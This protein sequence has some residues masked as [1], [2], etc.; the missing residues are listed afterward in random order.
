MFGPVMY[1]N[2]KGGMNHAEL[3]RM[4]GLADRQLLVCEEAALR[5]ISLV[6]GDPI[7]A[8][9]ADLTLATPVLQ[10]RARMDA[11]IAQNMERLASPRHRH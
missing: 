10:D 6:G 11:L 7:D 9:I 1:A 3:M 5:S 2:A 8:L 4:A